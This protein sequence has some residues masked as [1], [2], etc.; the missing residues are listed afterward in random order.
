MT[1]GTCGERRDDVLLGDLVGS[2]RLFVP[3]PLHPQCVPGCQAELIAGHFDLLTASSPLVGDQAPHVGSVLGRLVGL[4]LVALP[5][6]HQHHLF[7]PPFGS[8]GS[9][10][11]CIN[12]II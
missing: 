1:L 9:D 3:P 4:E 5:L 8:T 12:L 2:L 7:G 6:V 10:T 11:W